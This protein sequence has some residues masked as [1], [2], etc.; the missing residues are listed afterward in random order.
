MFGIGEFQPVAGQA[1]AAVQCSIE[2]AY[3]F[4]C[5]RFFENYPKWCPQVVRLEELSRPPIRLGSK[6]RQTMRDRG[7]ECESTFEVCVFDPIRLFEIAGLSEPFRSTY[8]LSSDGGRATQLKFTFE[9]KQLDL[10]MRPFQKLIRAAL[11]EGAVQTIENLKAL[12]E[13][14]PA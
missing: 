12:L 1:E 6:G 5:L 2:T 11:E 4:I 14:T 9:L 7:I 10:A 3:E 8:E 13:G